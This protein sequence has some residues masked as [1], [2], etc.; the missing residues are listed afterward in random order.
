MNLN[1]NRIAQI[2]GICLVVA[3][4]IPPATAVEQPEDW[5]YDPIQ[6]IIPAGKVTGVLE[7]F[8]VMVKLS[9]SSGSQHTD[10][11]K[12]FTALG[13]D[14]N[15][16][17]I[18]LTTSDGTPL[19]TE[20]AEWDTA[21]KT[22]Y[23]WVRVP[24]IEPSTATTMYLYFDPAHA[25]MTEFVGD[26]GSAAAQQ[27]WSNG[28][29]GVW[30]MKNTGG[31][32]LDS[33]PNGNH[34]TIYGATE[35]DGPIGRCLHFNGV[36]SYV[37]VPNDPT[38]Q[39]TG[40]L[41]VEVDYYIES[42][43][44][45]TGP[46][47]VE[48]KY[49][50]EYCVGG[51]VS[52]MTFT[53]KSD[54]GVGYSYYAYT[55]IAAGNRYG[56]AVARSYTDK[57]VRL[58]YS[59]INGGAKTYSGE[60]LATPNDLVFGRWIDASRTLHGEIHSI[61]IS[62]VTRSV[63][64]MAAH[65][66][67]LQ[68]ELITYKR[69]VSP[70]I[71]LQTDD[72]RTTDYTQVYPLA[73]AKGIPLTF[74][75]IAGWAG[76]GQYMSWD[77]IR[78]LRDAGHGIE[79]HTL[80]HSAVTT[81]TESALRT[82]LEA[83]NARFLAN[84]LPIP[85]HHC[86]PGT[87]NDATSR[88][89]IAEYRLSG[90]G[91]P[92]D[93]EVIS[94][95][96]QSIDWYR[97]KAQTMFVREDQT[98]DGVKTLID[99]A[100]E[101]H[102][103]LILLT[104]DVSDEPTQ[105]GTHVD[106]FAEI[107]DY[108]AA[109]RDAGLIDPVTID[110]LYRAMQGIRTLPAT[111]GMTFHGTTTGATSEKTVDYVG[112]VWGTTRHNNPE[113]TVPSASGYDH[114]WISSS[115]DYTEAA[116]SYPVTTSYTAGTKYYYRAAARIDGTWYYGEELTHTT[117]ATAPYVSFTYTFA[118]DELSTGTLIQ[119]QST[120][121]GDATSWVWDFGDG[122][123]STVRNP[124]HTY[125]TTGTY[126]VTLTATNQYGSRS[127]TQTLHVFSGTVA[128]PI[129]SWDW[130]YDPIQLIIPAGKVTGVLE[131]FPV[132]VKLSTSSGSQHT[133]ISK[134][135]TALGSD[136]NRTRICLTTSDGTPLYTEIA[137][138]DTANKTAY[139]WVRVP[140]I[141]PSTATTMYLY[142]DP[143]HA[144]M[145]EFVGDTGS[146]A[147]Q[148]VWSNGYAGVWH[149]KNTGG[150][151]LDSSPNGN[152]GT[153][154]G[155][156]ETDGPIGR[157]LHFNGVDSYVSVPND[158][159][160][161]ITGDLTV[162]VDYYIESLTNSTGPG[163]VEKKYNG[164]YCVGGYVSQ[165]T[166]TQKSDAG[167]GYSY[168]AYTPIAAGNRYG[169]AVARSYTD[170]TVRLVYSGIN[171]GAKTYSGEP[172]ATP[173]DLVFGRW[174]DAS[175]TLH[176]E[177]HSIQISNVTR[178]VAWMAAHH[179][180]LQDELITYKRPVSPM[181]LLQTDDGRTTDYTQVYPLASA[182]GIP[183]TFHVIAGWAGSGQY[184]SWDQIR[185]LRDAGHGIECHTLDHS[186]VTTLTES[187]LRTNLE[188]VNARFLANGLPIPEHHCYPGTSND[189]TSRAIIAEY[190]L[191]GRGGPGDP[192]VISEWGQSID[193]YRLKAQTMFVREDQTIDGVKT[194]ID[195]AIEN[196]E[197]LILLTHD[198]S[199]EPTQYGTHVDRFAEILDYV[200][201]KRDAGLIDP[202]TIDGLYRAMQGIRT[203]PATEGMTFH[204]TT[205]GAT[206]EKT[207][208]YVG[209]VWGTTRHNNPEGTV[210]SASGYDHNWISSSGDYTE[211]AFSYP[212]TTSYTA[213]TKYYYRAAARID[214]TWY[215]GEE[216]TH[217]TPA[218]APYVSF[219]YTFAGDELS[220]GTLIQ[221]QSTIS[222]DATSWVWDF[223]DGTTS[224][225]RN[226]THTYATTGTYLVT[227]TATN[228]YGSRS[229]TQ[230][231]HV[232]S[233]TVADPTLPQTISPGSSPTLNGSAF[234][235]DPETGYY[236]SYWF[237]RDSGFI[238]VHG[239]F[240]SLMLP[241]TQIFGSW[242]FLI[243]WGTLCMGFYLYTQDT[244]MPFIVG[245]LGGS[246]M[247]FLMGEDALVVMLLTM[248]F[249][250]GGILAKVLL[251]RV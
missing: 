93:P 138:W 188:A 210:P 78:E 47:L 89:I 100:I 81:L 228:Q 227:L 102:E 126:L 76:S 179:I 135:F 75:V 136:A 4:L 17:R 23:L 221:F 161:Q 142:F 13:S 105:Y 238:D 121:S 248:A 38:L 244:T 229:A 68:D 140:R 79:C 175:R 108:V 176:G 120:I 27:V 70:M 133:D 101:N 147:A 39:I 26:T 154:Y 159:T 134:I 202:V 237:S 156:T 88:A 223:G 152:H 59:G 209:F 201:A 7:D 178:S 177:I 60:P 186:A 251:G 125:A 72:G 173:N 132:M 110:G 171:G 243:I 146:A 82:N 153:I 114:N 95:W 189:A 69:P 213:G 190:R 83:V 236:T 239:L 90:R 98:I 250:G 196:H 247:A 220:T 106:R 222:G 35:T 21:N 34:G 48:K 137:E 94:E 232:F 71:L 199:D 157:C 25:P 212:V 116:F 30:H 10:I 240:F 44:N 143:A 40:D 141:E 144:P 16:T 18:C 86:Y 46:G 182:K 246:M 128:D 167:V 65:H 183:L 97:L 181:I 113:G 163:L 111:E 195:N 172:L 117:P 15:R 115:G 2:F 235:W 74:H 31:Q 192:E 56:F 191:S 150:Q 64:W 164:E 219:T 122:T 42:L 180:S 230:T 43:T 51:Y 107:L 22:A 205:T 50:G 11:S 103:V 91:G 207:V 3:L 62:N 203:L 77:Q 12:I 5:S 166:F 224:T 162:E 174:I 204:G 129:H 52:Q 197:V 155:A 149:M 14:A 160:L 127:A 92:G 33:S 9:T 1:L 231:L 29:A 73:S 119:F 200:A 58:V 80:D 233:G 61:Q 112:F 6:L 45:S 218:T 139:L 124:T 8:P 28:Y 36:D 145:T 148:Q 57:T 19:Y 123:T 151:V 109:K 241:L 234:R 187:A 24:R 225:V 211:A 130:S 32:V 87:S 216:L 20:I 63:A 193:W 53:Q 66:I 185:E 84:G 168:Y 208:D 131:D 206:S 245:V 55:P 184:M 85:E 214:G 67:S 226:P 165:M 99:N 198:V 217:T 118:G 169:F 158:P 170:K 41:T 194:L 249:A 96:G 54:A 49:N 37:S 104:H 215:Y 242:V